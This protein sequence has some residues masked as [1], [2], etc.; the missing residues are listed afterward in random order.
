M[1]RSHLLFLFL[2]L[3]LLFFLSH[4]NSRFHLLYL[5]IGDIKENGQ[6]VK[7]RESLGWDHIRPQMDDATMDGTPVLIPITP[8]AVRLAHVY[9]G[10]TV[11][12]FVLAL[13]AFAA[14][15]R[16]RVSPTWRVRPDDWLIALGFV[17]YLPAIS[18]S[19]PP[20]SPLFLF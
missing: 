18:S 11:V 4:T 12:L 17:R 1:T 9:S 14:R 15:V 19:L 20:P 10:L 13:I 5:D 16:L 2:T 3:S 8:R 7:R 6:I